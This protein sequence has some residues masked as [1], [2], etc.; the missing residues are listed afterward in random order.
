MA[1]AFVKWFL[2][3]TTALSD[4]EASHILADMLS[5]GRYLEVWDMLEATGDHPFTEHTFIKVVYALRNP[6]LS[7]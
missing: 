4:K 7:N 5:P 6:D 1:T 2:Q 3:E